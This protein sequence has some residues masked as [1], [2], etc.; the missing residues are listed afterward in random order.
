MATARTKSPARRTPRARR[1][2][3]AKPP[4]ADTATAK[5]TEASLDVV[6]TGWPYADATVADARDRAAD[7]ADLVTETAQRE[8]RVLLE[9]AEARAAVLLGQ[10]RAQ[11]AAVRTEAAA[12]A[13]QVMDEVV[14]E[15]GRRLSESAADAGQILAGADQDA[16][17]LRGAARQDARDARTAARAVAARRRADADRTGAAIVR[18]AE[19]RAEEIRTTAG[20]DAKVLLE[21]ASVEA[22]GIREAAEQ[23]LAEARTAAGALTD[24]ARSTVEGLREQAERDATALRTDAQEALTTAQAGAGRVLDEARQAAAQLRADA[25][26]QAGTVRRRADAEAERVR[27]EAQKLAR[28]LREDAGR[29]QE[30]ARQDAARAKRLAEDDIRRLR[31]TA[32]EDAERLTRTARQEADRITEAARERVETELKAAETARETAEAREE[33]AVVTLK[34][35]DDVMAEAA[36]RM[37]RATDRTERRLER[38]RLKHTAREE[39]RAAT[40]GRKARVREERLARKAGLPT[41]AER[42]K[43]FVL[44]N[45]ERLMVIGPITAP[46]AVAWTGQA[47]FAEDI[48]GWVAPFTILF[49]AGFELSTAFVGWMYHQAR[50]DGDAGTLYRISTWVFAV[51]AAVMNFWHASG[52]V[53]GQEFNTASGKWVEQVSY[54]HFTPKAVAFAAMSIVGMV[55]WELYASLLH[56]RKLREDGMAAK[57]RPSISLVRWFRFPRH[58]WTAW[59]MAITDASLSTLDRAWTAAGLDLEDRAAVRSGRTLHRVVVPR[60]RANDHGPAAIPAVLTLTRTDRPGPVYPAPL[61]PTDRPGPYGGGPDRGGPHGVDPVRRPVRTG[62]TADRQGAAVRELESGP[63]ARTGADQYRSSGP[64]WT[65][66]AL[67]TAR[68]DGPGKGVTVRTGDRAQGHEPTGRTGTVGPAREAR[69]EE[70]EGGPDRT[71][72]TLSDQER[73][74]LDR[75]RSTNQPL[76]RT[77][78]ATAVR[79]E[80]GSISTDRAGQISVALKQHTVR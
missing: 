43:R 67:P 50:K 60:P 51:G 19:A 65:A 29:D 17:Q 74:A 11:S 28:Q 75:L 22:A 20:Q 55:L 36:A 9:D 42:L 72:I 32:A 76:N 47:G 26:Q 63:A 49:A 53:T 68:T 35:A 23:V 33:D 4:P 7:A 34:A 31:Q 45:S 62:L 15:A 8:V 78:I 3:P 58:A 52:V 16:Q 44:V 24:Q 37:K 61:T 39:R 25:E 71:V 57:A 80:G 64:D 46:M 18:R 41:W 73:T 21:R 79:T 2:S 10:A 1:K 27:A 30:T 6:V 59:S 66:R 70:N 54:W 69:S 14:S 5:T 56:R 13:R 38:K 48:L 40:A 77:N 12:H